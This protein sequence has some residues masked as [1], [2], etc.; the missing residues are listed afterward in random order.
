MEKYDLL[1]KQALELLENELPESLHY[2]S[3]NHT[4][5]V[6]AVCEEYIDRLNLSEKEAYLLRIGALLHDIGFTVSPEEHEM[7]GAEIASKMM[8]ELEFNQAD[9]D[10]VRGLIM[11]TKIPQSPKTALEKIICDADLDYLGK[12]NYYEI[13]SKLFRELKESGLIESDE[14][15]RKIQISFLEKH[16]YHTPYAREN[17]QPVKEERLQELRESDAK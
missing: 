2:H 8:G 5:E 12:D 17:R 4:C 1:K 7:K 15:W 6:L 10:L 13:S 14:Q 3:I 16:E 9:I 11:A